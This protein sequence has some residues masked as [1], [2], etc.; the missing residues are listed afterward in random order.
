MR[1]LNL[2]NFTTSIELE[3]NELII[4][5]AK[6]QRFQQPNSSKSVFLRFLFSA[7]SI[8]KDK[9]MYISLLTNP[10]IAH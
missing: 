5:I 2:L 4:I 8:G 9:Y 3:M 6:R 10:M 7:M 1:Y